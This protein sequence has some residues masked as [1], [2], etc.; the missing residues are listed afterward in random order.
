MEKIEDVKYRIRAIRM[1]CKNEQKHANN[2]LSTPKNRTRDR[3]IENV[4][5]SQSPSQIIYTLDCHVGHSVHQ[6]QGQKQDKEQKQ[7]QQIAIITYSI[8]QGFSMSDFSIYTLM[9][10]I[11]ET[12]SE[13]EEPAEEETEH[14]GDT[15]LSQSSVEVMMVMEGMLDEKEAE[16]KDCRV[17]I[18][19]MEAETNSRV[20]MWDN[21]GRFHAWI[22]GSRWC[23]G[24]WRI[25]YPE[26]PEG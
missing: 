8:H 24:L 9:T 6:A 26:L 25:V 10:I 22:E 1:Q 20:R 23:I 4:Q 16:D 7:R 14:H 12:A 19:L 21:S 18:Q 13:T 3:W 2:Y 15:R 17:R 11:F 5:R